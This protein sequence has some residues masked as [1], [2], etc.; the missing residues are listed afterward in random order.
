MTRLGPSNDELDDQLRRALHRRAELVPAQEVPLAQVAARARSLRRRRVV[1]A[2]AG[3]A[4]VLAAVG[5]L[6][7]AL[8]RHV[9]D[10]PRVA[11]EPPQF[12]TLS[13]AQDASQLPGG[14]LGWSHRGPNPPAQL[15]A[16]ARTDWAAVHGIAG[17]DVLVAPLWS[18]QLSDGEWVYVFQAWD[19]TRGSSAP[20]WTVY[21]L[22]P[23]SGG[24]GVIDTDVPM[25]LTASHSSTQ[26]APAVSAVLTT[27]LG[28]YAVVLGAPGTTQIALSLDGL[29]FRTEPIHRGVAV[30][31]MPARPLLSESSE[32]LRTT[33]PPATL[34]APVPVPVP[35]P[36]PSSAEPDDAAAVLL[37]VSAGD[38]SAIT[39]L[40]P[41]GCPCVNWP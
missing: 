33:P 32:P 40:G 25:A 11:A 24:P 3:P 22:G 7:P 5:V 26:R 31:A 39:Y 10:R 16:Q 8:V 34:T 37:R 27:G 23:R 21:A 17:G 14:Y 6:T 4:L 28:S 20:V 30:F 9:D 13:A 18:D 1:S 15:A 41:L 38:P 29:T 36:A 2:L 35:E 12:T 19:A